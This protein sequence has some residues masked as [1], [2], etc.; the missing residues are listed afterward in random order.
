VGEIK[1]LKKD[2]KSVKNENKEIKEY[3]HT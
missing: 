3:I 1:S 2:I